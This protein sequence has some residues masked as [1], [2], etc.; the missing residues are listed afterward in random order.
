MVEII[1]F[2][3]YYFIQCCMF[4]CVEKYKIKQPYILKLLK[5]LMYFSFTWYDRMIFLFLLK[6][7]SQFWYESGEF[8]IMSSM[9]GVLSMD[10][11]LQWIKSTPLM[12]KGHTGWKAFSYFCT[13]M[14]KSTISCAFLYYL[15]VRRPIHRWLINQFWF[16]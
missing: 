14:T 10:T 13:V 9:C 7:G 8:V 16:N 15:M 6:F 4:R 5:M 1:C 12:F 11:Q 2:K 3:T